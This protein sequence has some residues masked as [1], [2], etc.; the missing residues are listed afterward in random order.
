MTKRS[1]R[2][3][4]QEGFERLEELLNEQRSLY[5]QLDQ[6]VEQQ[7]EALR[8]ADVEGLVVISAQERE[9]VTAIHRIDQRRVELTSAIASELGIQAEKPPVLSDPL[10]HSGPLRSRLVAI[11]DELRQLVAKTRAASSVVRTAAESLARHMQGIVQTVEAGF[12]R[13]GVYERAGRIT[14][15]SP[16]QTAIDIRS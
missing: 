15:G 11:A 8:T 4:L 6:L 3:V 1:S 2:E 14:E 5:G 9:V 12:S 10:E 16:W 7:R 13:A